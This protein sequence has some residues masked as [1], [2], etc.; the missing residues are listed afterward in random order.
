MKPEQ[1][2]L[3]ESGWLLRITPLLIFYAAVIFAGV[4][5]FAELAEEV[6]EGEGFWFDHIFLNLA[7]EQR[8]ELLDQFFGSVT[9]LGSF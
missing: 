7:A 2:C 3:A 1:F 9:R 6:Y 4:Y 8:H 5:A